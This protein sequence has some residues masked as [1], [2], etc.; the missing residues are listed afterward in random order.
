MKNVDKQ[1]QFLK[2]IKQIIS[3]FDL[4]KNAEW[5]GIFKEID[6]T[7]SIH[8]KQKE[9]INILDNSKASV[10]SLLNDMQKLS[11]NRKEYFKYLNEIQFI[12]E[13]RTLMITMPRQTGKTEL[14]KKV[15]SR[16]ENPLIVV[17]NHAYL[18]FYREFSRSNVFTYHQIKSRE[19]SYGMN[20]IKYDCILLDEYNHATPKFDF[21]FLKSIRKT[22][23]FFVFGLST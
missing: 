22:D 23:N 4:P 20:M 2:N 17:A 8:T 9:N 3:D 6:K 11:N 1:I 16:Y 18:E 5:G 10:L 12:H 14:I 7:I 19:F 21:N 13:F 15:A